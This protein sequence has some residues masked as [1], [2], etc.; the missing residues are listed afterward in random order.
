ME[1]VEVFRIEHMRVSPS[2]VQVK[3]KSLVDTAGERSL[4]APCAWHHEAVQK[5]EVMIRIRMW[6]VIW[7]SQDLRCQQVILQTPAVQRICSDYEVFSINIM[8]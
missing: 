7:L 5:I 2:R 4:A 6:Q 3:V 1:F 8:S